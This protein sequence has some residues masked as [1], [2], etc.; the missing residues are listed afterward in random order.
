M[1]FSKLVPRRGDPR[2][3][4]STR[5]TRIS[6]N[7]GLVSGA[8]GGQG[9]YRAQRVGRLGFN[10]SGSSVLDARAASTTSKNMTSRGSRSTCLGGRARASA[11]KGPRR[12]SWRRKSDCGARGRGG[13]K[14]C[15]RGLRNANRVVPM[16]ILLKW[17]LCSLIST[18]RIRS[19]SKPSLTR[20]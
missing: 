6:G 8:A 13:K 9:Q 20:V 3:R 10:P 1:P 17:C 4:S 2:P 5:M 7:F 19:C 11:S 15:H 12:P 18:C 14:G 16:R